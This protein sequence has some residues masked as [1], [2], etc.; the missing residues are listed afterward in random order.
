[1]STL[2]KIREII[3]AEVARASAIESA[4]PS[5]ERIILSS[6]SWTE[7][8]GNLSIVVRDEGGEPLP[9]RT[10]Q[11]LIADLRSR[12]PTLFN[13]ASLHSNAA[14]PSGDEERPL[15]AE[16]DAVPVL[17]P[18]TL[19]PA[20]TAKVDD[21][22]QTSMP[23]RR[24]RDWLLVG[25]TSGSTS[26][27]V[28]ADLVAGEIQGSQLDRLPPSSNPNFIAKAPVPLQI[29]PDPHAIDHTVGAGRTAPRLYRHPVLIGLAGI[30]SL[31]LCGIVLYSLALSWNAPDPRATTGSAPHSN[32][33]TG[34]GSVSATRV[35]E[36][37]LQAALRGVPEVIDTATLLMGSTVVPLFGVQRTEGGSEPAELAGYLRGREVTCLPAV[38]NA[39]AYRCEVQG[40]DLSKVVLFN[41]G[42]RATSDA[43]PDLLAAEAYA[44]GT[45][46]GLWARSGL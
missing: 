35:A 34:T 40:Q 9:G 8:D 21:A 42:G 28:K 11:D 26:T 15:A 10:I 16:G 18:A 32:N 36:P 17:D 4:R 12:R 14:A 3:R 39:K 29:V 45:K 43:T 24:S 33:P 20:P 6:L 5:L 38:Y 30:L 13:A 27:S 19:V 23:A 46:T 7:V 44:R 41:G 37:S 22:L 2:A 1:M 31:M 25:Q